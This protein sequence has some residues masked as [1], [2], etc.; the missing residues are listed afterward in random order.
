MAIQ[1]PTSALGLWP[2]V[3]AITGW[4]LTDETAMV[5]LFFGWLDGAESVGVLASADLGAL[6][7][8][9][10][11]AAGSALT[12]KLGEVFAA[13]EANKR[14]MTELAGR[15][16][17]FALEVEQVKNYIHE[18]INL[19]LP[20]Y[21]L[22]SIAP[23][24]I[25]RDLQDSIVNDVA[26]GITAEMT[27]SAARISSQEP[28]DVN[29]IIA[30]LAEARSLDE[31][32]RHAVEDSANTISAFADITGDVS[33]ALSAA[34]D[35]AVLAGPPGLAV[36]GVAEDVSTVLGGLAFGGHLLALAG[37][38][39]VPQETLWLDVYGLTAK[40]GLVVLAEHLKTETIEQQTGADKSTIVDDINKYW[41]AN[42]A[43]ITDPMREVL[44]DPLVNLVPTPL[45]N[46]VLQGGQ[47]DAERQPEL[48]EERARS[49]GQG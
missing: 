27:A 4:P 6:A 28:V 19:N 48:L 33:T 46:A 30:R 5:D 43:P 47:V 39:E 38:A 25:G 1:E 12:S 3:K 9:W 49:R 14:Q 15:A 35:F 21:G 42:P 29:S 11:D 24:F 22:A 18:A 17:T 41:L 20:L 13:L 8:A 10:P 44:P 34:S 37:G 16:G 26:A 32:V 40:S 31:G 36:K 7:G 2:R 45:W 23:T